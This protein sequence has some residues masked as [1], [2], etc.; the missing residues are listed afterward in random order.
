MSNGYIWVDLDKPLKFHGVQINSIQNA[1]EW[2]VWIDHL[3]KWPPDANQNAV[4]TKY[5]KPEIVLFL[6]RSMS[7]VAVEILA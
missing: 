7:T 3:H 2:Q 1:D 6:S 5:Q 4:K